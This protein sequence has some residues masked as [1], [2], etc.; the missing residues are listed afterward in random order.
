MSGIIGLHRLDGRPVHRDELDAMLTP[1]AHRGPDGRSVWHH[2][3]AGLGHLALHTTPEAVHET[4]PLQNAA[5]VLHLVADARIDN[6][7]EMIAQLELTGRPVTD[8][9]IVLA[10]Y[11]RWGDRCPERLI[12]A[13]AFVIWDSRRRRLYAARDHYGLKPL[14]Y[15]FIPGR[16]FAFGSEAK[17]LLALHE[18]PCELDEV[19]VAAH[20]NAPV[21]ADASGTFYRA[22]RRLIPGTYITEEEGRLRQERY[23]SLDPSREI[24]LGSDA[25]YAEALRER[26]TEAV[27]CRTRSAHP[28]GAMLSGGIDSSS[29]ACVAAPIVAASGTPLQTYSAVF[30][31][32]KESDE[33]AYIQAVL[34]RHPRAIQPHYLTADAQSP[35][36]DYFRVLRHQDSPV[37]AGNFYINWIL[38][39]QAKARGVRVMLEGFDGD[40]TLS[41]GVGYLH[42]L[43]LNDNWYTLYREIKAQTGRSGQPWTDV[44]WRWVKRY[45]IEPGLQTSAGI[46]FVRTV[47]NRLP[48]RRQPTLGPVHEPLSW[49]SAMQPSF[50]SRIEDHLA[51]RAPAPRS[52]RED[53]HRLMT[54]PMMHR[55]VELLEAS[56]AAAGMEL[57]LP[58]CDR[59]LLEFCLAMPP[60]QKRQDGWTRI[61]MRRAM[62]GIL[63]AAIQWRD[64]KSDLGPSFDR[65]LLVHAG[66]RLD[67]LYAH[68]LGGISRFVDLDALRANRPRYENGR[69]THPTQFPWR[70]LSLAI[71][72]QQTGL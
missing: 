63:P 27:R 25:E 30:D 18:V 54:R 57:R 36:H 17:A 69:A 43:A 47:R 19:A 50:A 45:K 52:E 26:F 21:D 6:R 42:E 24:R 15:S 8:A 4:Y 58:F 51:P 13:Y 60:T 7:A 62:E 72:L 31:T 70:A 10:A 5:G 33:R 11:E 35:L 44:M 14:F 59:R 23:W 46:R 1:L 32:V 16:L 38:H 28:V 48:I 34:R 67:D 65:G 29:I 56:T 9:A 61:G 49:R 68:D 53:H 2:D 20:L 55:V 12:G 39:H 66:D 40:T 3:V 37:E 64:S 41:H 71:W 22:I